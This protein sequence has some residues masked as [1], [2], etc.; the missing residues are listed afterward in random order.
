MSHLQWNPSQRLFCL[1]IAKPALITKLRP[2]S[3]LPTKIFERCR[4]YLQCIILPNINFSQFAFIPNS[5][6]AT[7]LL[8]IQNTI[9]NILELPSTAA[10]SIIKVFDLLILLLT[11]IFFKILQLFLQPRYAHS[12]K[13]TSPIEFN[14]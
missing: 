9:T 13:I 8:H 5:S 7:C 6:T 11:H 14:K 4:N 2:I 1:E 3:L 10:V 12:L